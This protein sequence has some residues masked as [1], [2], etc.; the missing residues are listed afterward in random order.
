MLK[1]VLKVLKIVQLLFV[2]TGM[3]LSA[4]GLRAFTPLTNEV[5]YS[6]ESFEHVVVV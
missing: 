4:R 3:L 1:I 2:R 5:Q 6:G